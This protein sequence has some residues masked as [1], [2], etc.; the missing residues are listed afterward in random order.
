MS[1]K[2]QFVVEVEV[3][4][5]MTQEAEAELCLA[6]CQVL[7]EVVTPLFADF[8]SD[9]GIEVKQPGDEDFE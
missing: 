3:Y 1:R 8:I 2:L 6:A 9:F 7:P 4:D 5:D